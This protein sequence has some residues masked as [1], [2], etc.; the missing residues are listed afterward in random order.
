MKLPLQIVFRNMVSSAAVEANVRAR[1]DRLE[2]HYDKIM[3]CRVMIEEHHQHH[4]QGNMF[5]VRVD[6]KVPGREL[7]V[8]R[9]SGEHHAHEDVYVAIRDAFDAARRQ[10]EDYAQLRRGDVKTHEVAPHGHIAELHPD[11]GYGKIETTDGRRVYFHKNSVVDED[12][13][14]FEIGT[15]VRFAE[16]QGERGPQATTVHL[17]GK[18]HLVS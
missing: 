3:S 9:A 17:I 8:S 2:K 12:F 6:L 1:V 7:V 5:Q 4:Q 10:L 18:H 14:N 11:E 13:A 16:E 15:E